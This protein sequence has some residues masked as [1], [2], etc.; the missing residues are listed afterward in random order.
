MEPTIEQHANAERPTEV[1]R[2][3]QFLVSSLAIGLLTS[4][5]HLSQRV[6]GVPMV[7]ALLIV[8]AVFGI[9]FLLIWRISAMRWMKI[10][11]SVLLT[12]SAAFAVLALVDLISANYVAA[13]AYAVASVLAY[14]VYKRRNW[15][16]IVWLVIVLF[17]LPFAIPANLQEIR[18]NVLSGTLS[19]IVTLLQ[20]IGTYLLFTRN[21]NLWFRTRK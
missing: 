10:I 15:A 3:F 16:R 4:I 17:G 2:A 19:V 11:N 18:R 7:F 6:S 1:T 14:V 13:L 5:F 20:V 9:G 8:I 12:L 21:S